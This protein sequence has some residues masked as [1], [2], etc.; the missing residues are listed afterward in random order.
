MQIIGTIVV[1]IVGLF[2][3]LRWGIFSIGMFQAVS[4]ETG[5]IGFALLVVVFVGLVGYGIWWAHSE[6]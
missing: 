3:L 4:L 1:I 2:I 5:S 6:E